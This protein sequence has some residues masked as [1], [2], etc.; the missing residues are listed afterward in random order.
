MFHSYPLAACHPPG[1]A[2]QTR[3]A[4]RPYTDICIFFVGTSA[5]MSSV[6]EVRQYGSLPVF[7]PVVEAEGWDRDS[8]GLPGK[9][10]NLIQVCSPAGLVCFAVTHSAQ[11]L[12]TMS[13]ATCCA[14]AK[15]GRRANRPL[16]P[17]HPPGMHALMGLAPQ[18]QPAPQSLLQGVARRTRTPIVV[19]MIHGAPLDVEWLHT[20]PRV[21]A[22]L[23]A[24]T[25]GQARGLLLLFSWCG[26]H[27]Y[28]ASAVRCPLLGKPDCAQTA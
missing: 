28:E 10:L 5:L 14:G 2:G 23:S 26:A 27:K 13:S 8:L 1:V 11:R 4:P 9:Q 15:L 7:S 20:S 18:P 25:P 19:V 6:R 16:R 12:P 21:G 24:W 17:A 22:I 3:H